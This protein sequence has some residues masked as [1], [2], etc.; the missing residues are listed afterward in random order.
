MV[1]TWHFQ[2]YMALSPRLV[3]VRRDHAAILAAILHNPHRW[4]PG[5]AVMLDRRAREWPGPLSPGWPDRP[6]RERRMPPDTIWVTHGFTVV[7][8]AHLPAEA[9]RLDDRVAAANRPA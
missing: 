6:C 2:C 5:S 8:V 9:I 1:P 3:I 4:P 7:H